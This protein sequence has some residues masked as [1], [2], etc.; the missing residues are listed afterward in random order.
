[1]KKLLLAGVMLAALTQTAAARDIVVALSSDLRSN[2]PG[3]NRD[4]NT[5]AIMMHILEGLV[6]YTEDGA[7]KPLLAKSVA[8]SDDGLTYTFTLR[9]DVTFHNGDKM[10]ADDVVWSMNRY[11]DADSK[12]RCLPDFDGSRVVKLTGVEKVDDATVTMTIAEPSAVFLG[13]MARPECGFT[14]IISPKSVGEDGSFVAPIGT[15]PFKW[16]EWKKGE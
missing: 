14:G 5:D 1:M 10:T 9:D 4:G 2:D 8:M 13:L 16:D 3:V 7:V 12:W 11:M 15:G 6:G